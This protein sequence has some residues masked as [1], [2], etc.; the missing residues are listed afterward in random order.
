MRNVI[1]ILLYVFATVVGAL[2]MAHAEHH[3]SASMAMVMTDE[4]S[5][6]QTNS[7]NSEQEP[8]CCEH[9]V[10][11]CS[12][13]VATPQANWATRYF[14]NVKSALAANNLVGDKANV[15]VDPGPPRFKS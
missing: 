11:H 13:A 7:S 6:D 5:A 1:L 4:K 14:S 8:H 9:M 10:L 12:V 2:P 3:G 15:G